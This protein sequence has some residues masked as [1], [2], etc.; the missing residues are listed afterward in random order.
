MRHCVFLA[1]QVDIRHE[2]GVTHLEL[3]VLTQHDMFYRWRQ[4]AVTMMKLK[5]GHYS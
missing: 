3:C 2:S 4:T 5:L 1:L